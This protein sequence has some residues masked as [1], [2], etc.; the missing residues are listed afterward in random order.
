M[1]RLRV[2]VYLVLVVAGLVWLGFSWREA[3]REISALCSSAIHPGLETGQAMAV[4][5]TGDYL[6]VRAGAGDGTL[7]VDSLYNLRSSRCVIEIEE[8]RVVSSNYE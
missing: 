8:G 1:K 5:D 4:L 7:V 6:R 2:S 3:D